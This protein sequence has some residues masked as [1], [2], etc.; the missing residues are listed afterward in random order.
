M[1][2]WSGAGGAIIGAGGSLLGGLMGSNAAQKGLNWQKHLARNQI[3]MRVA[4]AKK[5]GISP[6][7]ALG[8]SLYSGGWSSGN[9]L[10]DGIAAAGQAIGDH[11][12]RAGE[13][14]MATELH[15]A[16]LDKLRAETAESNARAQAET[17]QAVWTQQQAI[18][19]WR[20][21]A[22]QGLNAQPTLPQ[23]EVRGGVVRGQPY[24]MEI[25]FIS[26]LSRAAGGP[27][28]YWNDEGRY[29]SGQ[30]YE[31][32]F[33]EIGNV[34]SAGKILEQLGLADL[35]V[36]SPP[37]Q[38]LNTLNRWRASRE[39]KRIRDERRGRITE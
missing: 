22:S 37:A 4:D 1:S 17:A 2:F 36:L 32:Q 3:Q 30:F 15:Q 11:V 10:G 6:L 14:K 39:G 7:A 19:S 34:L 8:A 5:A 29:P 25:P 13:R 27:P 23:D 31:D 9:A 26:G 28:L 16:S 35:A 24:S 12:S 18:D 38:A 21:R 33:Q 20:A